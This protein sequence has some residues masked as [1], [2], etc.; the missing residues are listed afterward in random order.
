MIEAHDA[1]NN[2]GLDKQSE[3]FDRTCLFRSLTASVAYTNTQLRRYG[4]GQH[5]G[6]DYAC[7]AC[8]KALL[9]YKTFIDS[10]NNVR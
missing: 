1:F 2:T 10:V 7:G 9:R 4:G 6:I 8:P 5:P 3:A